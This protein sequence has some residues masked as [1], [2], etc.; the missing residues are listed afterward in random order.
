MLTFLSGLL[1][2]LIVFLQTKRSS[3][4]RVLG[5]SNWWMSSLD[6]TR[7][8]ICQ[9]QVSR[10]DLR[11]KW[12]HASCLPTETVPLSAFMTNLYQAS[13]R[14]TSLWLTCNLSPVRAS[15]NIHGWVQKVLILNKKQ[16]FV[17]RQTSRRPTV[18]TPS[19]PC[20]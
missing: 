15:T 4:F 14:K 12:M 13:A 8:T 2:N 10:S 20:N 1:A 17:S 19:L 3:A 9:R 16:N 5:I 6:L 7:W 11:G 18:T